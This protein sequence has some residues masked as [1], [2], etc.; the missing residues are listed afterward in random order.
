MGVCINLCTL[1]Y[2]IAVSHSLRNPALHNN[3]NNNNKACFLTSGNYAF[4]YSDTIQSIQFRR[5]L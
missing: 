1:Y 2:G 5:K 3:N 4:T